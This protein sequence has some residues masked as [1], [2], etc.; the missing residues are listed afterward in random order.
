MD[1]DKLPNLPGEYALVLR[2]D[3]TTQLVVGKLG[4][5]DLPVGDYVYLGS[6]RGPGGLRARLGRHLRD[7]NPIR[8]HIDY[9]RQCAWVVNYYYIV[10]LVTGHSEPIPFE[11]RWSQL[12]SNLPSASI[13]IRGFGASDCN[14]NCPAH[15][16]AF[17]TSRDIHFDLKSILSGTVS[18]TEL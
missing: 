1:A 2:L 7:N 9:L 14:S 17:S 3:K 11:C 6:A 8:W 13:P 18:N 4:Q 16:V 10:H 5:Y 15:L 12:L